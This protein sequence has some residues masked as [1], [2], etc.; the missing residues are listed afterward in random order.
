MNS[1]KINYFQVTE[2]PGLKAT[3]EQVSRLYHRYHFARRFSEGKDVL[4]VACGTGIGLSYIYEVAKSITG[5]DIDENN[6]SVAKKVNSELL[7]NNNFNIQWMDACSLGFEDESFDLVFLF[8]AIYYLKEPE[9]FIS[10]A[11]RVLKPN[12]ILIICSVNKDWEDFHPS[13]YTY[14]YFSVPELYELLKKNF[15]KIQ[16][17]GAFPVNKTGLRNNI[18]SFIK[19][20]AVKFNLIPGSLK[21]RTYLKRIFMGKLI[22]LPERIYSGMAL[23]EEPVLISPDSI[24]KDYKILYVIAYKK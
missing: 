22:P 4:E 9:R 17:Y 18:V 5:V 6:L 16:I 8:E 13:P 20:T 14:R 19:R 1:E 11:H 24:N 7:K 3:K 2:S 23:F 12:G 15:E 10:E 21:A